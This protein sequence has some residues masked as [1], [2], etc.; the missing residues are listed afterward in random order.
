MASFISSV[1]PDPAFRL[2][3]FSISQ[4]G[5]RDLGEFVTGEPVEISV[6]FDVLQDCD[7]LHLFIRL[8]DEEGTLLIESL[9]NSEGDKFPTMMAG[10]YRARTVIPADL[11][12]QRNYRI[13]FNAG[14]AN[15]RTIFANP[16][17]LTLSVRDSGRVTPAYPGYLSPGRLAPR[18]PWSTELIGKGL[19]DS[20]VS[21]AKDREA[22]PWT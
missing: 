8:F 7:G 4:G 6:T 12:A 19:E 13:E 14:I 9:H 3:D 17:T 11:L 21:Q 16:L 5:A 20:D 18:F 22:V 15:A 1:P 2:R 10:R